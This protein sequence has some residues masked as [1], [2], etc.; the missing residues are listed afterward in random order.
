MV[1]EQSQKWFRVGVFSA[2]GNLERIAHA[3]LSADGRLCFAAGEDDYP[4]W[5]LDV[6]T[7]KVIWVANEFRTRHPDLGSY[8]NNE[9]LQIDE[10]PA[11]GLYRIIG[12]DE[13]YPILCNENSEWS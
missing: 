13:N 2:G 6:K 5:V 12:I 1:N 9:H 11:T 10:A 7:V 3:G 8:I 4:F